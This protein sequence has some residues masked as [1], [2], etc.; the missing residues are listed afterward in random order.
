[1]DDGR[2]VLGFEA[3]EQDRGRLLQVAVGDLDV[4]PGDPGGEELG[5]LL[6]VGSGAEVDVVGAQ[7]DPGELGVGVGV[8]QG[9]P[10]ADEHAHPAAGGG[11]A[12]GGDAQRLRPG[13]DLQ[14]AAVLV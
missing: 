14:G 6:R 11:Q 10:S 5:L 4:V 12:A 13:G 7:H 8:L 3:G 2:L 9:E 1:E